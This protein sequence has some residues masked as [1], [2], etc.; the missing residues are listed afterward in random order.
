MP[1]SSPSPNPLACLYSIWLFAVLLLG[2]AAWAQPA[3]DDLSPQG[4][5]E[6]STRLAAQQEK[7]TEL[8]NAGKVES[9]I[10]E[11]AKLEANT[12]QLQ[13]QNLE[14][15]IAVLRREIEEKHTAIA[16]AEAEW[17]RLRKQ[18]GAD[19]AGSEAALKVEAAHT[20]LTEL[21]QK[22]KNNE[23][24][25]A[26]LQ[27]RLEQGRIRLVLTQHWLEAVGP[28]YFSTQAE[29]LE[30]RAQA[31]Q[32]RYREEAEELREKLAEFK[33]S[34]QI[35]DAWQRHLLEIRIQDAEERAAASLRE[36]KLA[37]HDKNL[38][39]LRQI[40]IE[41]E[42]LTPQVLAEW[43]ELEADTQTTHRL[44]GRKMEVLQR[45]FSVLKPRAEDE[46]LPSRQRALLE[47]EL[48]I[49]GDL[50]EL[51]RAQLVRAAE[52][53]A[54]SAQSSAEAARRYAELSERA[55]YERN[56]VP[57]TPT[58]WEALLRELG[59]VPEQSTRQLHKL[60]RVVWADLKQAAAARW[61][62]ASALG[63]LLF[64]GL[65]WGR[66]RLKVYVEDAHLDAQGEDETASL[67][68][69]SFLYRSM[70]VLLLLADLNLIALT[71]AL[72]LLLLIWILQPAASTV[73][74]VLSTFYLWLVIKLSIDFT[75]LLTA[76]PEVPEAQRNPRF[77]RQ[78]RWMLVLFGVL[79]TVTVA[80]H[81]L[82]FSA[83][84]RNF[85]DTVLM[86][87]L[88]L[89]VGPVLHL[90]NQSITYLRGQFEGNRW[91]WVVRLVTFFVVWS[92]LTVGLLGVLGYINLGWAVARQLSWFLLVLTVWLV[93]RG[94]LKD[95]VVFLKNFA[96]QHSQRY[97]L[98]WTQDVIPL[99]Q[100][101]A[102][103]GLALGAVFLLL[104]LNGW[105]TGSA[106]MEMWEYDLFT[107]DKTP[108]TVGNLLLSG[109][110]LYLVF[111]F[112]GWARQITYRWVYSAIGD[113]GARH[114]LSVFTQYALLLVGGLITLRILGLD[115]TT[116][117]V[118][119]GALGVGMGFGLQNIANNFVSG[120]LLLAA[121]PLRTGDFVNA[122]GAEGEV[123]EIGMR[124][125]TIRTWDY[126]EVIVPNSELI[127][128][129]F[130]NWTRSDS[131]LRTVLLIGVSYASDL[132]EVKRIFED[133]V[134]GNPH[135]L[136]DPEP[137]VLLGEF[138]DSAVVFRIHYYCNLQ[139]YSL[140]TLKS[141]VLF[142][143]WNRFKE[144]GIEI[145]FPQR[146][147]H[148]RS[149]DVGA[150]PDSAPPTVFG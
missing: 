136:K 47:Q 63:L 141:E 120:L 116:F 35:E 30:N 142:T 129:P 24:H 39:T 83:A 1:A 123:T 9:E 36:V 122:A 26:D 102:Q 107:F 46:S 37:H 6:Y 60:M 149:N 10:F 150:G 59:T 5:Q 7:L 147:I 55:L 80:L 67:Y 144:A 22:Q 121:R 56:Q 118:F 95:L 130:T 85:N 77:Y 124:S 86:L 29:S 89:T 135:I 78:L 15:E 25:L 113:L 43:R 69:K 106:V 115:L 125:I 70:R 51:R 91:I 99:L 12:A 18:P 13:V 33:D 104:R 72:G 128:S 82:D 98:L 79:T 108:I 57:L 133:I 31:E 131:I 61:L 45:Q 20:A 100:R 117:A 4:R 137:M 88:V 74:L 68:S 87:F 139:E 53:A 138:A 48:K 65:A 148:I 140:L 58:G 76:A 3:L 44:L 110:A 93:L 71:A 17:Q 143:I 50:L 109:F 11:Q 32:Q 23:T 84:V 2:H 38:K 127:S 94:L 111:W 8:K 40:L 90:R 54:Q 14:V 105:D 119:A 146:D 103:V 42:R 41:P 114:S 64:A 16:Q 126:R 75:W 134:S 19:E 34:E 66:R 62:A 28:L 92:I 112:A 101:L 145:P 97:G 27:Q 52:F 96:L 73:F 21:R 49:I 132:D 81:T